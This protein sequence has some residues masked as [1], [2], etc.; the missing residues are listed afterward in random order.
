MKLVQSIGIFCLLVISLL[1]TGCGN[2]DVTLSSISVTSSDSDSSITDG[3]T[4][5]FTATGKYSDG[6]TKD[7]TGSVTW[8]S[9][10]TDSNGNAVASII[11]SGTNA[12]LATAENEG[13]AT[14]TATITIDN[15][16][17]SGNITLTVT[18][19]A[20]TVQVSITGPATACTTAYSPDSI[21]ISVGD[22]VTWTN[23]S[24]VDLH[25]I[26]STDNAGP[27][28]TS[29]GGTTTGSPLN[30]GSIA[31]NG[32]TFSHT[33]DTSGTYNYVC[34]TS[35]HQMRGTVIVQ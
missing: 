31:V 16:T 22:T 21:T 27:G 4:L 24:T 20:A 28:C 29:G 11:A 19:G 5:Q 30:S 17:I 7:L 35:L 14:I 26:T 32:G 8:S 10:G 2:E 12:G 13:T 9:S 34:T 6:S 25:T 23:S 15:R 3:S 18:A 1:I 33:F